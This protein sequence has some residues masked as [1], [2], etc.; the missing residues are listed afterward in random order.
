MGG[1][2]IGYASRFDDTLHGR[3]LQP[4]AVGLYRGA[5]LSRHPDPGRCTQISCVAPSSSFHI[6]S[7]KDA[8]AAAGA[9]Y[10][11]LPELGGYR[12]APH[13]PSSSPNDGWPAGFL[14]NYADYALTD[15]FRTA[16]DRLLPIAGP[17]TAVMC[18]ERRWT[19]CHRQIIAEYLI[20]GGPKVIH[21]LDLTTREEGRLP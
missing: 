17:R 2:D 13:T 12:E 19:D 3:A 10:Y 14:R 1:D 16:L 18:A 5:A 9:D 4:V 8:L 15:P 7:L 20:V 11:H 6:G 21:L